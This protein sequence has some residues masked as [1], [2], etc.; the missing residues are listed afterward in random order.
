M[1]LVTPLSKRYQWVVPPFVTDA[2]ARTGGG[3]IPPPAGDART[4]ALYYL[5]VP[6]FSDG[7]VLF[8][9]STVA[10][11]ALARVGDA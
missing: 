5:A 11:G 6:T 4:L 3:R 7:G 2:N 8:L 1:C 10:N 9:V